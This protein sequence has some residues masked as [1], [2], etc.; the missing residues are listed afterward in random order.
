MLV[1]VLVTHLGVYLPNKIRERT[2]CMENEWALH[3]PYNQLLKQSVTKGFMHK[4]YLIIT[5]LKTILKAL[6]NILNK[7]KK[8][9]QL[10]EI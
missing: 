5:E 6:M 9:F 1:I 4:M 8:H 3:S 7:K 2:D 10:Q